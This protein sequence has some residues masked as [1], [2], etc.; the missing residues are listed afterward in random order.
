MAAMDKKDSR[1]SRSSLREKDAAERRKR[2]AAASGRRMDVVDVIEEKESVL[3]DSEG[4]K[5]AALKASHGGKKRIVGLYLPNG[6][7]MDVKSEELQAVAEKKEREEEKLSAQARMRSLLPGARSKGD[8]DREKDR[9]VAERVNHN[10]VVHT[11]H[12]GRS[13]RKN[14]CDRDKVAED[15]LD[16][17]EQTRRVQG[18][19]DSTAEHDM[20]QFNELFKFFDVDGDRNWGSIEFAQRMTDIGF[21]TNVEDAANLL[22]FAGV[23]DVDRITYN[24]FLAMMPK[25]RAYRRM[26]EKDAMHHFSMYDEGSGYI[27]RQAL[28]KVINSIV[29]PDGMN[30]HEVDAL[31]KKSDREKTG[32]IPFDF[33]IIA[34]FGSKPLVKYKREVRR[35]SLL[36]QI[37]NGIRCCGANPHD[38]D[39]RFHHDEDDEDKL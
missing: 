3:Q 28:K 16:D 32:F 10:K 35:R 25:L 9:A 13:I 29:G 6:N 8:K 27:T 19:V 18:F 11:Y 31:V 38:G 14:K 37:F 22:Y 12:H 17:E 7:R 30:H 1:K 24:D 39:G 34:L 15:Y 5:A 26:I 2:A 20:M 33:F 4:L 23:R 21:S 36:Q